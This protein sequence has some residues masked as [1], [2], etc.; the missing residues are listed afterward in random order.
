MFLREIIEET[1]LAM[2]RSLPKQLVNVLSCYFISIF[3]LCNST[4]SALLFLCRV[5]LADFEM[6]NF[7]IVGF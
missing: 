4:D 7:L 2:G 5:M 1:D 3:S 6:F